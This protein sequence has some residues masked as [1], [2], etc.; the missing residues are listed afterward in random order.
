MNRL[1]I[2]Y[3]GVFIALVLAAVLASNYMYS[4]YTPQQNI[5]KDVSTQSVPTPPSQRVAPAGSLE[6]CEGKSEKDA[7]YFYIGE[8]KRDGLCYDILGTLTCGPDPEEQNA[9]DIQVQ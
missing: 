5:T 1:H 3:G 4:K 8:Q 2:L 6:S 9:I 7:C